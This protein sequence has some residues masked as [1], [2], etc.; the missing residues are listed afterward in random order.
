MTP[1]EFLND[2]KGYLTIVGVVCFT[3]TVFVS[4]V[5]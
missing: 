5:C 2:G 4:S 1:G 3:R